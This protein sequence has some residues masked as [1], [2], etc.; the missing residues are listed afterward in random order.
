MSNLIDEHAMISFL[1][2]LQCDINVKLDE[3]DKDDCS[4]VYYRGQYE[5][6]QKIIDMIHRN[7]INQRP[8]VGFK[9]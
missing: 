1:E 6:C 2:T 5:M 9:V 8:H 7:K 3:R 4:Y